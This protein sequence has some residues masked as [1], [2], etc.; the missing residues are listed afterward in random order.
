MLSF[1]ARKES[2]RG[3]VQSGRLGFNCTATIN[4][5]GSPPAK[6][7]AHDI[8]N[9]LPRVNTFLSWQSFFGV[10]VSVE[11]YHL[12]SESFKKGL[13][14]WGLAPYACSFFDDWGHLIPGNSPGIAELVWAS[15]FIPFCWM[16]QRLFFSCLQK[17][18]CSRECWK[19]ARLSH[20]L[21]P[22][23]SGKRI[24]IYRKWNSEEK[25]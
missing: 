2:C 20:L 15:L 12:I 9:I 13:H 4:V 25:K 18:L 8:E 10:P 6:L 7:L 5:S 16:L 21:P 1:V 14:S 11:S 19:V 17:I 22:N 24:W 23:P 3:Q